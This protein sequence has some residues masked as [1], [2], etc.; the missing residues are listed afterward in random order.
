[1]VV[2]YVLCVMGTVRALARLPPSGSLA[3][4]A[5]FVVE[6]GIFLVLA[7][8]AAEARRLL[9]DPREPDPSNPCS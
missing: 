8:E 7:V 2:F 5:P 9:A 3:D 4:Y 1:M 6:A